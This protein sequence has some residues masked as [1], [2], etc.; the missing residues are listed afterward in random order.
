MNLQMSI[1]TKHAQGPNPLI[2]TESHLVWIDS[3][4]DLLHRRKEMKE[5]LRYLA[6]NLKD[7]HDQAAQFDYANE[8]N[9]LEEQCKR[10]TQGLEYELFL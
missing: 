7:E 9:Q 6:D 2:A 10:V 4:I 5:R 3:V 1:K 8:F